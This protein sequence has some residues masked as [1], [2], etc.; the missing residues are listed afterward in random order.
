M[1]FVTFY[2]MTLVTMGVATGCY[3]LASGALTLAQNYAELDD[4]APFPEAFAA[5]GLPWARIVV[6]IGSVA[7]KQNNTDGRT[8]L[9]I[10]MTINII[11]S[12]T[13]K[14]TYLHIVR[15]MRSE[16]AATS[17]STDYSD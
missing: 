13:T 5:R 8:Q 9:R 11:K 16:K 6:A 14:T 12:L 1:S 3:V 15:Y 7:G 10:Y 2:R 17:T 4:T